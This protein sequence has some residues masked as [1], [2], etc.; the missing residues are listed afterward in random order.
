M[1]D[2]KQNSSLDWPFFAFDV[3]GDGVPGLSDEDFSKYISRGGGLFHDLD[4]IIVELGY[5]FYQLGIEIG[6]TDTL[7]ALTFVFRAPGIKQVN[8]QFKV[9]LMVLDDFVPA[10]PSAENPCA[11]NPALTRGPTTEPGIP[12]PYSRTRALLATTNNH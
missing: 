6:H 4:V 12:L 10:M 11:Q 5:G 9:C 3:L 7:G 1:W 8:L 2:L